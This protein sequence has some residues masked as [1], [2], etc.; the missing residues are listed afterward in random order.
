MCHKHISFSSSKDRQMSRSFAPLALVLLGLS[1]A[2][3]ALAAGDDPV[4]ANVNGS[5][6]H[7]SELVRQKNSNPRLAPAPMNAVYEPLL[8]NMI[9]EQLLADAARKEGLLKDPEVIASLKR[10]ENSILADSFAFRSATK[11]VTDQMIKSRYDD[12]KKNY[13]PAEEIRARHILVNSQDEANAVLADLKSGKKF[14][15]LAAEKSKD[16]NA[17]SGGDLGFF[18]KEDMVP[19]FAEAAFKLKPGQVSP[20]VQ[21]QFGWH[22]IKGE[23][24]RMS[25]PPALEEVK[26][27][28]KAELAQQALGKLIKNLEAGA[29]ISKFDPEGKPLAPAPAKK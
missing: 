27:D 21:T 25:K 11:S 4:V 2:T 12:L 10:A 1:L 28:L 18:R 22:V 26:D 29:K 24:K 16:G 13:K 8:N 14:E 23:E 7:L 17:A 9:R 15:D 5:E 19:E 6:L 3:P 20:P